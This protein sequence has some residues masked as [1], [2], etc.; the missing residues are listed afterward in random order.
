MATMFLTDSAEQTQQ[1]RESFVSNA[2][3]PEMVGAA[4]IGE[5]DDIASQVAELV[6]AGVDELIFNMP[7]SDPDGIRRAGKLFKLG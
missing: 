6:D 7:L 5:E 1:V 3:G 2:A 4:Q